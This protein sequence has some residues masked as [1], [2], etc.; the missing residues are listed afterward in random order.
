MNFRSAIL[1]S[2]SLLGILLSTTIVQAQQVRPDASLNTIVN[3]SNGRDFVITGGRDAGTNLFHSFSEFSIPTGGAAIFNNATNVQN[4]F[5][6]VTGGGASNLDGLLKAN[7]SANV[8][9]LNPNGILFGQGARLD[10]NGSLIVST[11]NA[12]AFGTQGQFS[13]SDLTT[14]P[15]LTIQP[16]ALW[17]GANPQPI[18]VVGNSP[19]LTQNIVSFAPA[20]LQVP[21]GKSLVLA[22][23]DINLVGANIGTENAQTTLS[24]LSQSGQMNLVQVGDDWRIQPAPLAPLANISLT[25]GASLSARQGSASR[26]SLQG[27]TVTLSDQ[28]RLTVAAPNNTGGTIDIQ[29]TRVNLNNRAF[30]G[31]DAFFGGTAGKLQIQATESV[32]IDQSLISVTTYGTSLMGGELVVDTARLSVLNGGII[33]TSTFNSGSAGSIRISASDSIEVRGSGSPV[34]PYLITPSSIES[35]AFTVPA[36][37]QAL[38]TPEV[39]TGQ[40]GDVT[41]NANQLFVSDKA[42]I[43]VRHEGTGNAGELRITAN[44]IQLERLGLLNA[45]TKSGEGGNIE[46]QSQLLLLRDQSQLLAT[47]GGAGNGGNIKINSPLIIGLENSDIITNALQGRGGNIQIT[48]QGIIGLQYRD[49]L[50]PE[51]DISASSEFGVNGTVEVSTIGVDPNSGLVALPVNVVDPS[52]KIATG[53]DQTKS[54]SFIMTGRGGVPTNP[55]Q[56]V[57]TDRSWQDLRDVKVD[58]LLM[59][60]TP[61]T[62]SRPSEWQEATAWVKNAQGQPELIMGAQVMSSRVATCVK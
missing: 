23:G 37:R 51:N 46:I 4:I 49:R 29:A 40:A 8:F 6:R 12:I 15:L 38:N 50:T 56:W 9:L 17:F 19:G 3:S 22:G 35:A 18:T 39:P 7:G 21:V 61:T 33:G 48:T 13:T 34:S 62:A 54:T 28:S 25:Q 60:L 36:V 57:N 52:Q 16:S 26:I 27:N 1:L 42:R 44:T 32:K 45:E 14:P 11:A 10:L 58:A 30:I 31:S 41:I 59:P 53:C 20:Q 5:S 55:S 2:S 24:G 47:A 43:S